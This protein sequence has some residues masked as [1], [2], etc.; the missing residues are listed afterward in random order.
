MYF[1]MLWYT[2]TFT[3]ICTEDSFEWIAVIYDVFLLLKL[4]L[5]TLIGIYIGIRLCCCRP[6]SD[7]LRG[8]LNE[9][10]VV[11]EVLRIPQMLGQQVDA[12]F[13]RFGRGGNKKLHT[14]NWR[15]VCTVVI[16][17]L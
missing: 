16:F 4:I 6:Q 17:Q 8:L 14:G 2:D 10:Q 9:E 5:Y 15:S 1:F 3:S 11:A 12:F 7:S 13:T